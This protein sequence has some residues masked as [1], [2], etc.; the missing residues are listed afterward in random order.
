LRPSRARLA[1]RI[2]GGLAI[3]AAVFGLWYHASAV[4]TVY[5]DAAIESTL[6]DPVP[7]FRQAFYIMSAISVLCL[8]ALAWCGIQLVRLSST[9]WWLLAGI[10]LVECLFVFVVGRLWL[11][12]EWGMSIGAASGLASGGLAPQ[13]LILFPVWAPLVAWYAHRS[14]RAA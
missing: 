14:L 4:S 7:Y 13:L 9:W 6:P 2:I 10:G 1:L 12:P 8:I 11:H 5:H 3:L